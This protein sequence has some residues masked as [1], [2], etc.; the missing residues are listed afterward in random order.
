MRHVEAFGETFFISSLFVHIK[1][2]DAAKLI[3]LTPGERMVFKY[4]SY[5][6]KK[7]YAT[8]V[9][10]AQTKYGMLFKVNS[11]MVKSEI[12]WQVAYV[13]ISTACFGCSIDHPFPQSGII[14]R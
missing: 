8:V 7:Y 5:G 10:M 11:D 9:D 4:S 13:W 6:L 3:D 2:F 12:K 1:N 14:R